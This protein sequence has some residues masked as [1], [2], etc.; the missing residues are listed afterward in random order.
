[1]D[2]DDEDMIRMS[3][4]HLHH[5]LWGGNAG[6][7]SDA[8]TGG[9]SGF[10]AKGGGGSS[11][12]RADRGHRIGGAYAAGTGGGT[13]APRSVYSSTNNDNTT[14]NNNDNN[15]NGNDGKQT[16]TIG[17]GGSVL[18]K[19]FLNQP[20]VAARVLQGDGDDEDGLYGCGNDDN[21]DDANDPAA[22][23]LALLAAVGA[24]R[25]HGVGVPR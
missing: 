6:S 9:G 15:N 12:R 23:A 1:M 2:D 21:D 22:E 14:N 3:K 16:N 25:L 13:R 17:N 8:E 18:S 4:L 5:S 11:S 20:G 19:Y 24:D 7:G 10:Y